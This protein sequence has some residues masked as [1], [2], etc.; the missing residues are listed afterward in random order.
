MVLLLRA[1]VTLEP[2]QLDIAWP[3]CLDAVYGIAIQIRQVRS[4]LLTLRVQIRFRLNQ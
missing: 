1:R 3:L 4:L 2:L